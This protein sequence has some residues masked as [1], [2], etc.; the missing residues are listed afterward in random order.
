MEKKYV[1]L[2]FDDGPNL[3]TTQKT[4]DILE[5]YHVPASFFLIGQN[6][7]KDTAKSVERALKLG[8][9]AENHSFTHSNMPAF[10]PEQITDEINEPSR[11]IKEITGRDPE[12]F[13]PPYID[14]DQKMFDT[15]PLTFICGSGCDDWDPNFGVE[16]RIQKTLANAKHGEIFL[17]HD[18]ADNTMTVPA[19]DVII[20]EL[21]DRG[22]TFL[23]VSALFRECGVTPGRNVI[24][25]NVFQES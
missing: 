14:Y 9:E 16:H 2:S 24:Y 8:C 3:G 22:Y 21:L 23:T 25:S 13:R 17:L 11:L 4:L 15:I 19:I 1:A 20:P 6:I 18:S 10:T 7:G 5:K 12:F